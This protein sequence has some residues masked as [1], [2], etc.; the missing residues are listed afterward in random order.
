LSTQ[1]KKEGGL[2]IRKEVSRVRRKSKK[3]CPSLDKVFVFGKKSLNLEGSPPSLER[4]F[5]IWKEAFQMWKEGWKEAQ[6]RRNR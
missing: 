2:L 1:K 4:S 5:Q 6:R 3:D